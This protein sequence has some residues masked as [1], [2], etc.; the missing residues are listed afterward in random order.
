MSSYDLEAAR[1]EAFSA[2][3]LEIS[4]SFPCTAHPGHDG[5][6]R[7][8]EDFRRFCQFKP[9]H[10]NQMERFSLLL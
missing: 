4:Q 5:P 1:L 6:C 10:G 3:C 7:Y 8:A 2:G 9:F